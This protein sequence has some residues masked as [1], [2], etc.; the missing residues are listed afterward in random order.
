M[1]IEAQHTGVKTNLAMLG[2]S[3]IL[4]SVVASFLAGFFLGEDSIGGAR[5][6]FYIFHWPVIEFFTTM[7]WSTAIADYPASNNPLLY[8]I[9]SLLPLHGDQNIYHAITFVVALL[10]WPLLSWA[11]HRRYS[12]Y[13]TDWL[14][15][16]FGASTILISPSF[17]SSAFW[18]TTDYLPFVFVA[19]TSLLLSRYQ[20][21]EV[22][23]APAIG[24]FTV[25]ALAVVSVCAFYVRQFY[26]FLPVFGVWV[27]LTRTETSPCLVLS[28]FVLAMVPEIFLVYLWRG[29]NPPQMQD[30]FRPAMINVVR[31]GAIIGL[32]STPIFIGCIRRS[33]RD[34]LPEW[35][36]ARSTVVAFGGLLVFIMTLMSTEWPDVGGGIIFKAGLRMGVLG[37]LFIL[38]VSYFGLVTAIVFS[39]RSAT[40]ALLAGAFVGP[41]LIAA[42][43]Y[44]HYLEPA[45]TVAL[46]LFA[47]T[48]TARRVFNKRVLICNLVFSALI[49][50]I[51]IVYYDLFH[52]LSETPEVEKPHGLTELSPHS[53]DYDVRC[54]YDIRFSTLWRIERGGYDEPGV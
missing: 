29:I 34:V 23:K 30:A 8:M 3:A 9:A 6:D 43:T 50:A 2:L 14:W 40:N 5:F 4:L 39:M 24:L 18:G 10:I 32:L 53:P 52:H 54:D 17:R 51:G 25:V 26:A 42:R 16:S 12:K 15:A 21:V 33:L 44:Q 27:V 46:F 41:F 36:G 35:W 1:A 37:T 45:L 49:L 48:Q 47:D 38:T 19:G 28:V 11:Y 20:D 31:A 22:S 7:S 13:G